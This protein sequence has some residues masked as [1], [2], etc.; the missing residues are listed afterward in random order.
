MGTFERTNLGVERQIGD[1]FGYLRMTLS[2]GSYSYQ[3]FDEF[4][5]V[6]DGGENACR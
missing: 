3:F 1:T 4:G 5:V 6:L 2:E